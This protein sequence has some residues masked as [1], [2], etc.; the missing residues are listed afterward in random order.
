[1][2][3]GQEKIDQLREK[4]AKVELGGGQKRIDSQ[5][6]KGKLTAR[7][8]LAKL[9]DE[10]SF[11]EMG[12]FIHHRGTHF[13][14]QEKEIPGDGVVTGYG[15][16]RGRLVFAYAEDF[17]VEGDPLA[18]CTPIRLPRCRKWPSRWEPLSSVSTIPV[19]PAFKK[20]LT[21]CRALAVFL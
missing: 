13:G 2:A 8:R 7:E 21:L 9:F 16:V 1:M 4:L 5:H 12:Q 17:T 11:T 18:K 20:A 3:T 14:M 6:K 19:A 15:T 10:G